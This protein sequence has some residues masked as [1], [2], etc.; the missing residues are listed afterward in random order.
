MDDKKINN[1]QI[2]KRIK[3]LCIEKKISIL[4]MEREL[5]YVRGYIGKTK[6]ITPSADRIWEIANYLGT[7]V[8][9]LLTGCEASKDHC[10]DVIEIVQ[11]LVDRLTDDNVPMYG[12]GNILEDNVRRDMRNIL[13][14]ASLDLKKTLNSWLTN[15]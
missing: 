6:T 11:I 9:Y 5:G 7:S 14:I 4:A 13:A 2:Y 12:D 10:N 1:G 15:S 8:D 3:E